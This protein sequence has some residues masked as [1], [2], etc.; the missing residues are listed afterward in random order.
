MITQ[1]NSESAL[2]TILSGSLNADSYDLDELADWCLKACPGTPLGRAFKEQLH[3]VLMEPGL[4]TPKTYQYWTSDCSF[5]TQEK[6]QNHL[7]EVWNTCFPDE[8]IE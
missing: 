8:A 3:A 4:L 5:R 2:E 1:N 6:L 7:K